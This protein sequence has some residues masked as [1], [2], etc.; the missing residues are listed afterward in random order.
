M[1]LTGKKI[2]TIRDGLRPK[3]FLSG[4]NSESPR[5]YSNF[6]LMKNGERESNGALSFVRAAG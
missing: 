4:K 6:F 3:K 2:D 1:I 5:I